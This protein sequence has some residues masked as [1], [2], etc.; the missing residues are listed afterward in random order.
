VNGND[1][2]VLFV[3]VNPGLRSKPLIAFLKYKQIQIKKCTFG[4]LLHLLLREHK[5]SRLLDIS[6]ILRLNIKVQNKNRNDGV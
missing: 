1:Q 6:E 5:A 4:D 3:K 2:I